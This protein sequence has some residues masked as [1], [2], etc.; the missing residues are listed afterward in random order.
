MS[1]TFSESSGLA[2]H[3][4]QI[5]MSNLQTRPEKERFGETRHY[6]VPY[7]NSRESVGMSRGLQHQTDY[8]Q[9]NL[10]NRRASLLQM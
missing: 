4:L 7:R 8:L 5:H 2:P 6:L 10:L 9:P 3:L 1:Q